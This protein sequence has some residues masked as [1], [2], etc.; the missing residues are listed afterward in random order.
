MHS[1]ENFSGEDEKAHPREIQSKS[2]MNTKN[3]FVECSTQPSS[4]NSK[5]DGSHSHDYKMMVFLLI[6]LVICLMRLH[7]EGMFRLRKT[8]KWIKLADAMHGSELN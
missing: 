6:P 3:S 2:E 5:D 7:E 8:K 1:S 4:S